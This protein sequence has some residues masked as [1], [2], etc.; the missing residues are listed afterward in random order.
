M[1]FAKFFRRRISEDAVLAMF[2]NHHDWE[3]GELAK[4]LRTSPDSISGSLNKLALGALWTRDGQLYHLTRA[5][6]ERINSS[7]NRPIN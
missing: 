1:G 6:Y 2:A 4:A 3:I 7:K 5:G